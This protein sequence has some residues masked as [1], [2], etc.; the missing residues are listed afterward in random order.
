[1]MKHSETVFLV[2]SAVRTARKIRGLTQQELAH[3]FA[4]FMVTNAA[5]YPK[6]I[7]KAD[8]STISHIERSKAGDRYS[9]VHRDTARVL[10]DILRVTEIGTIVGEQSVEPPDNSLLLAAPLTG[11]STTAQLV[12]ILL[13]RESIQLPYIPVSARASFVEMG[14]N[15]S[16]SIASETRRVYLRYSHRSLYDGRVVFEVAGDSMEPYINS[17]DEVIALEVP[18]GKW[19]MAQNGI[20]VVSYGDVVTI[21]KVIGNDLMNHGTLTLRPWRDE[22]APYII[23]RREIQSI[24]RVEEIMPCS[25]RP[26]L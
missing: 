18:E 11:N 12:G 15:L 21:K 16:Y 9:R 14:G 22:L 3:E 7:K 25:F 20:F 4:D 17:G 23:K 6:A 5:E 1:M 10:A 24:F 2:G 19:D 8:Y 26:L 13:E